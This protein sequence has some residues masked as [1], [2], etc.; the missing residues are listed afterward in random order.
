MTAAGGNG[1][2]T[3]VML[4]RPPES[5]ANFTSS[6]AASSGRVRAAGMTMAA[7]SAASGR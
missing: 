2:T 4:S 6:P 1:I 3:T 5:M 7:S